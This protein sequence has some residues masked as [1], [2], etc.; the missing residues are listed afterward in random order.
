MEAMD[1]MIK[2]TNEREIRRGG[3]VY[4]V[5]NRIEDIDRMAD[6][7]RDLVPH[8]TVRTAHGQMAE[9]MLEQIMIDFY[10]GEDDVLVSTTII[11]NG[12]DVANANTIIIYDAD[13]FC[14]SQLYPMRGRVG[15]SNTM[16]FSYFLF[17][18]DTVL[19]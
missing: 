12:L 16:A 15:R 1:A 5:Y 18:P 6:R 10:E 14:L 11:E 8:A 9:E 19:S 2:D 3:Q 7:I 13:R 17:R 4:F